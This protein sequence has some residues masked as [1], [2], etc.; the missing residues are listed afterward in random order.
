VSEVEADFFVGTV[1]TD[2]GEEVADVD[3]VEGDSLET[4]IYHKEDLLGGEYH[5]TSDH[6]VECKLRPVSISLLV[7]YRMYVFL[8]AQDLPIALVAVSLFAGADLPIR[9]EVLVAEANDDR[10]LGADIE[11]RD[12]EV[13]NPTLRPNRCLC[14][15]RL[16]L[17][18]RTY[19][20]VGRMQSSARVLH[21]QSI[22]PHPQIQRLLQVQLQRLLPLLPSLPLLLL[23]QLS[24][25]EGVVI[26]AELLH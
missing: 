24:V 12:L 11:D 3:T 26:F 18:P 2:G 1:E 7:G 25:Q 8:V 9:R 19:R 15:N 4:S 17:G 10:A 6:I 16:Q 22:T 23:T 13:V 14:L 21:R 20:Y 5:S